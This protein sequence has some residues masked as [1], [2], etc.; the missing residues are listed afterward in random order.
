[1]INSY[2]TDQHAQDLLAQLAVTSPND[3]RYS[4]HQGIIRQGSQIW[5]GGN[6]AL[7]TKLISAFQSSV[8]GGYSGVQATYL[9]INKMFAWRGMKTD[10][11]SYVK[12]CATY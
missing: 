5:V 3:Q 1:V 10:V 4:L 2:M 9:R 12:Q 7:K 11:D 6:S 8:L